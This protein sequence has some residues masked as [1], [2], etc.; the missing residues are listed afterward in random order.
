MHVTHLYVPYANGQPRYFDMDLKIFPKHGPWKLDQLATGKE[1]VLG[2]H[3]KLLDEFTVREDVDG[4]LLWV[5]TDKDFGMEKQVE[6]ERQGNTFAMRRQANVEP[7]PVDEA[8]AR[9][10]AAAAAA[11]T[12]GA[13]ARP[14]AIASPTRRRRIAAPR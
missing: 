4:G 1:N 2:P 9:P 5:F 13:A 8:A 6:K 10:A 14:A 7:R 12:T 11:I 3:G